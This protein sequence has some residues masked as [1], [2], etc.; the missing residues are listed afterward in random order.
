M[1]RLEPRFFVI[2]ALALLAC[3]GLLGASRF[4]WWCLLAFFLAQCACCD[5]PCSLCTTSSPGSAQIDVSGV[6]NGLCSHCADFN[7]TWIVDLHSV[8][9]N[10]CCWHLAIPTTCGYQRVVLVLEAVGANPLYT[11]YVQFNADTT[12]V[13]NVGSMY[14]S[15]SQAKPVVCTWN[16]LGMSW[17]GAGQCNLSASTCTVTAL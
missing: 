5:H 12:C 4:P 2:F 6:T 11:L 3:L 16:G 13:N 10:L 7:A 8:G 9:T 14:W 15:K 1:I 17:A